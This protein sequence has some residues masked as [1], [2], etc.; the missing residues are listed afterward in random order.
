M[1]RSC[2][3]AAA[4]LALMI[5][6]FSGTA[7]A[8][9]SNDYGAYGVT[10]YITG[11]PAAHSANGIAV[12]VSPGGTILRAKGI[13]YVTH[14]STGLYCIQVSGTVDVNTLVPIVGVDWSTSSGNSLL[15]YYRSSG[16]GCP[17][18]QIGV[19]TYNFSSGATVLSDAVG[20]TLVA[21]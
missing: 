9:S 2:S 1:T 21:R 13:L 8:K 5:A 12:L 3:V 11:V 6:A 19:L 14:P 16:I 17:T 20:F 10:P 15:A 4:G 18:N 7:S